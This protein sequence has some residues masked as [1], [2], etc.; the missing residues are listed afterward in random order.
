MQP[1]QWRR[2]KPWGRRCTHNRIGPRLS[3]NT[4]PGSAPSPAC[5]HPNPTV[6]AP[7]SRQCYFRACDCIQDTD[8]PKVYTTHQRSLAGAAHLAV[9]VAVDSWRHFCPH[10]ATLITV[11]F[12]CYAVSRRKRHFHSIRRRRHFQSSLHPRCIRAPDRHRS[13]ICS[14]TCVSLA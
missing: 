2:S 11:S 14:S 6:A 8:H 4:P 1:F 9:F 3:S 5:F 10:F 12:C 7:R 13:W